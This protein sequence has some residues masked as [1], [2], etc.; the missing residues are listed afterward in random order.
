MIATYKSLSTGVPLTAANI[1][2]LLDL[3]FR[4]YILDQALARAWRIGQD[5]DVLALIIKLDSGKVFNI[6][7][8]DHFIIN[9][10]EYNVELITGNKIP[11]NIPKQTLADEIDIDDEDNEE[12]TEELVEE[13]LEE[14]VIKNFIQTAPKTLDLDYDNSFDIKK[15][16]NILKDAITF[17]IK[18]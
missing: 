18:K 5:K 3:P 8:R 4:M 12:N 16:I 9:L 10:S 1:I 17:K 2:I 11:Y 7:D 13:E 14:E 15:I 6:T